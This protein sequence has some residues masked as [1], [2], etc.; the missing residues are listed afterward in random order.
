MAEAEALWRPLQEDFAALVPGG[1]LVVAEESGH[2]I[3]G[4]QPELV[5]T[6]I[7]EVVEAVRDPDTW[8][9]PQATPAVE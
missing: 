4:D 1:R 7:Q 9:T 5:I 6:A 3:Q 8:A 2:F